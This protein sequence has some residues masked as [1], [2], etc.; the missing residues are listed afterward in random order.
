M[1]ATKLEGC[2]TSAIEALVPRYPLAIARIE[3][4]LTLSCWVD[5]FFDEE[6]TRIGMSR[7]KKIAHSH[8]RIR[9]RDLNFLI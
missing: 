6:P 3:L 1:P 9:G 2:E 5:A 8:C 4:D 7:E